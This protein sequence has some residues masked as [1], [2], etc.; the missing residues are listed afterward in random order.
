VSGVARSALIGH[1]ALFNTVVSLPKFWMNL[2]RRP[3]TAAFTE[4]LLERGA[5]PNVRASLRKQ[6]QSGYDDGAVK[7]YR[8]VTAISWGRR[9]QAKRFVSE[10]A[11]RLIAE[12][13][14]RE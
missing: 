8:D 6:L 7:E 13:G 2:Q 1:T 12:R 14:G 4:L 9:F 5:N 11:I 3:E 10:A